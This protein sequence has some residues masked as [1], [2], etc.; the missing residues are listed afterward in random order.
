MKIEYWLYHELVQYRFNLGD[1]GEPVDVWT[2]DIEGGDKTCQ[3]GGELG[4]Q[5]V[6][7]R[8]YQKVGRLGYFSGP[9]N[10]RILGHQTDVK[11]CDFDDQERYLL[12]CYLLDDEAYV[13]INEDGKPLMQL[14]SASLPITPCYSE[15]IDKG[16][17]VDMVGAKT[18]HKKKEGGQMFPGNPPPSPYL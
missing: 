15:G 13:I 5:L 10:W 4:I 2:D 12:L 1:I 17:V 11:N 7:H 14:Q 6:S 3:F 9:V 8:L 16:V 18:Q